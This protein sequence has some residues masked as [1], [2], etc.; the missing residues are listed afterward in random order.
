[1]AFFIYLF[2]F[3]LKFNYSAFRETGYTEFIMFLVI[4]LNWIVAGMFEYNFGD[5]AVKFLMFLIMAI[6]VKLFDK[7]ASSK[8]GGKD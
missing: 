1:M 3:I 8:A 2:L 7:I 4:Y 5:E 6:N